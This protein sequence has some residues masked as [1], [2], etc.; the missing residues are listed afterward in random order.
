[1]NKETKTFI[2]GLVIGVLFGFSFGAVLMASYL[3]DYII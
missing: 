3:L 1:M 2:G